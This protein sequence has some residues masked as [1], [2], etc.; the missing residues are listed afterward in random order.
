MEILKK[1]YDFRDAYIKD[2]KAVPLSLRDDIRRQEILFLQ[3][4]IAP[5]LVYFLRRDLDIFDAETVTVA[6]EYRNGRLIKIG[7]SL[8]KDVVGDMD[9]Y[10]LPCAVDQ[11]FMPKYDLDLDTPAPD[12]DDPMTEFNYYLSSCDDTLTSAD[13]DDED[14][15]AVVKPD[16]SVDCPWGFNHATCPYA[17]ML[18]RMEAERLER[19]REQGRP[20]KQMIRKGIHDKMALRYANAKAE[21]EK[22]AEKERKDHERK[23]RK[24]RSGIEVDQPLPA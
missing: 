21:M 20:T 14:E 5:Q 4:F 22:E 16:E 18:K 19:E 7:M 6:G 12:V 24:V 17:M 3:N 2:G 15:V 23:V 8:N 1:L 11:F 10:G 13:Y 9:G